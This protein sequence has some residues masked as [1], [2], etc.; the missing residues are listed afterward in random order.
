MYFI[1]INVI[2]ALKIVVDIFLQKFLLT[3][4]RHAKH[5]KILCKTLKTKKLTYLNPKITNVMRMMEKY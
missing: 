3:T 4:L 5:S 2:A 1:Y